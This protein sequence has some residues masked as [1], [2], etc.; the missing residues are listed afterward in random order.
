MT[1]IDTE[2]KRKLREMGAV[3]LLEALES[4]DED[5]T[6]GMSFDERLRLVVDEA[7]SVF[8]HAKIEGLIRRAGLR[9]PA[10][11]LR[12]LDKVDERGLDQNVIA[13]LGTC[14]F[15]DRGQNVVFQGFTGSG[16]SYLGCAL[17]KRACQHRIRAHYIR[18]PDLEEAW[19]QAL[20]KPMGTTKFLKK[21]A[22]FS[23][24]VI[25]EWLLDHPDE[26]MRSMLLELLERRYDCA[27]TVFCTQYAKK[28]WHQRLGSGVHADAIMDRIVHNTV[29]VETG[30]H[31]M[32]EHAALNQ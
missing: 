6:M 10:A 7:H 31:N 23:V 16:K 28:D 32:R 14:S 5:L 20:D 17:A 26:S 18:M 27:S 9:Y 22:A 24:L 3:A 15:I 4:Q 25:D 30:S 19:A 11:D 8:N 29:W 21:Y 13:Q 2:T 12:Q 1:S